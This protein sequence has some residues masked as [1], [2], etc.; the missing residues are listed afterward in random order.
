M[1]QVLF[2]FALFCLVQIHN[3]VFSQDFEVPKNY[4]FNTLD[5]YSRY[6]P[7]ILKC[8]NYIENSPLD[9]FSDRRKN[10]N[11]FFVKWLSGTPNVSISINPYAMDLVEKNEYFLLIFLCGWVK[12]SI[13]NSYDNDEIKC[14]LAGLE[15]IIKVYKK[16][17]GVKKDIKVEKV[18]KIKETSNL[19]NW[20][21]EQ[22]GIKKKT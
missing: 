2:I 21:M 6:E 9:D 8:I 22:L 19:E 7:E 1:K 4:S 15:N 16:G 14:N 18:V 5:D 13:S 3:P 12:Y 11:A 20:I 17:K 10:I